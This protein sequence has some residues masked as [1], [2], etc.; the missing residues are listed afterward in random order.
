VQNAKKSVATA[1]I[2]G[3]PFPVADPERSS[4]PTAIPLDNGKLG[5][6]DA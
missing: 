4:R 3:M 6:L 5:L 2:A 1:G